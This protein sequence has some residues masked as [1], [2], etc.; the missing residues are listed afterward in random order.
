MVEI[1]AVPVWE[2]PSLPTVFNYWTGDLE[3][4]GASVTLQVEKDICG[5]AYF[6]YLGE[7][8]TRPCVDTLNGLVN[9]CKE[10]SIAPTR[11]GYKSGTYGVTRRDEY[12]NP[13]M[14]KGIDVYAEKGTP[15]YCQYGGIVYEARDIF[16]DG[17][18]SN[19]Y[20]HGNR[21]IIQSGAKLYFY[22]HL[23]G[24]GKTIGYN[25]R[26]GRVFKKGDRVY[27]GEIIG[28]A[29]STGNAV[30]AFTPHVHFEVHDNGEVVDPSAYINGSINVNTGEI[31][32]IRCDELVNYD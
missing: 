21:I 18:S 28:Y 2:V 30:E 19:D 31:T 32:G 7:E 26:A 29:G 15:I 13:K 17:V 3:R 6:S 22:C 11:R 20:P 1:E 10:M 24:G 9:M 16:Q 14:H 25:Y 27:P 5:V 12:G 8:Q 4:E 23:Q